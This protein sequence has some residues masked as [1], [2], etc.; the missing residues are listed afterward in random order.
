MTQ[1]DLAGAPPEPRPAPPG[2]EFKETI[3]RE[4]RAALF[5]Y[6]L[7]RANAITGERLAELVGLRLQELGHHQVLALKTLMRRVQESIADLVASGERIGSVS[8]SPAGYYVPETADELLEAARGLRAH[9][10]SSARRLR[11]YDRATA[12]QL[13]RLLGQESLALPRPG[14][15][16]GE[17]A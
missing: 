14:V 15:G 10:A 9:L 5:V 4:V 11:A 1:L 3:R 7:G 13:L 8:S 12:D 2:S 16:E 17:A 6:A